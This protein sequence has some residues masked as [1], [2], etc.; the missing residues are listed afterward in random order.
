MAT[1]V[2]E[3]INDDESFIV[4]LN[5]SGLQLNGFVFGYDEETTLERI[6]SSDEERFGG[7]TKSDSLKVTATAEVIET[8][9]IVLLGCTALLR[10]YFP[11]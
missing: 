8:G 9:L 6:L 10:Y 2:Y 11:T 7:H 4:V 3:R 1:Y 5:M